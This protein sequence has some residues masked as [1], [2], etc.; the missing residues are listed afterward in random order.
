MDIESLKLIVQTLTSLG[1]GSKEA[2]FWWLVI[3]EAVPTLLWVSFWFTVL[4]LAY[5]AFIYLLKS[6]SASTEF[7]RQLEELRNALPF[8]YYKSNLEIM[9]EAVK[10]L[11]ELTKK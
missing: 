2:F 10:K 11:T 3:H 9:D 4:V 5:K 1:A 7:R 6:N 8:Q